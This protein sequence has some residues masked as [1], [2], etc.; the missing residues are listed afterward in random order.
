V[1]VFWA[2]NLFSERDVSEQQSASYWLSASPFSIAAY[3]YSGSVLEVQMENELSEQI[4]LTAV[5]IDDV[6]YTETETFAVSESKV[7][8]ISGL[9]ACG[10]VGEKYGLEIDLFY[11]K[12]ASINIRQEG[13]FKLVGRCS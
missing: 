13:Q 7:V 8:N 11:D 4:T 10:D 9:P 1:I 5:E 2:G 6:N 12:G 3:K